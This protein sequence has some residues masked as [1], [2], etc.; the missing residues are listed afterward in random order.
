MTRIPRRKS[1][2]TS[3]R[4]DLSIAKSIN[5]AVGTFPHFD[6]GIYFV[7]HSDLLKGGVL[8]PIFWLLWGR[9]DRR[10]ESR[11]ND[12]VSIIWACFF[13]LMTARALAA[14]LPFRVRPIYLPELALHLPHGMQTGMLEAWSSLPSDHA[15]L[16][17]AFS[18]GLFFVS[19]LAGSLALRPIYCSGLPLA[20][21]ARGPVASPQSTENS[22]R[23]SWRCT[24][25][26]PGWCSPASSS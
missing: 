5:N 22:S 18:T 2:N 13:S 20:R 25:D 24:P 15:A 7:S 26:I 3:R 14:L 19:R 10:S 17:V 11:R 4:F 23:R 12:L 8:T 6:A 21:P 16:F 1:R 9:S